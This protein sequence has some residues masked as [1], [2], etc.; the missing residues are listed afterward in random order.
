MDKTITKEEAMKH[1]ELGKKVINR[2][3]KARPDIDEKIKEVEETLQEIVKEAGIHCLSISI[4]DDFCKAQIFPTS[5][6]LVD[7]VNGTFQNMDDIWVSNY[8]FLR[9]DEDEV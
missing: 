6:V 3:Y 4:Y 8:G 7:A 9:E 1:A 5:E 2:I